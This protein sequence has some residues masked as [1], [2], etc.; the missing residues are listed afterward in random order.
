MSLRSRLLVLLLCTPGLALALDPI[1]AP[2][3]LAAPPP[4]AIETA[5]GMSY[6]VLKPAAGPE[7]YFSGEWVEYRAD[8]WS[9]DGVTRASARETGP[10]VAMLRRLA[11]E[12]PG[13][14]R[15]ILTTPIGETRRWWIQPDRLL[16]G[17][18]GMPNLLHVID[19]TVV[20]ENNPVQVPADVAA[21]PA[22]ALRTSS[23]LA[24]K[25][26]ARGQG[27]GSPGPTS[28]IVIHYSGWTTDGQLFDSS[29]A[30]DQRAVFRLDQLIQG[31]QEGLRLMSRGDRYRFW[32]PGHLA[33]DMQPP[34]PGTPRGMLV[35]DV[36][37]Y[38][39]SEPPAP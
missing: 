22:D 35:F 36:T 12:Q 27:E 33:Y 21:P 25:V 30:R 3:P 14:A 7:R 13:L 11:A 28:E 26:L 4:Q 38:D 10:T 31:W 39:F 15:A 20:G 24:Y 17:Y 23:G 34:S 29:V 16:P 1:R 32:I 9:S 2:Q 37:L 6:V 8:A 19:L 18:P 5:S